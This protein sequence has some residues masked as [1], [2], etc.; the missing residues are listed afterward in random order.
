[1]IG[2]VISDS[3]NPFFSEILMGVEEILM[4]AGYGLFICNTNEILERE[5]NYLNKVLGLNVD[6]VIAA[7]TSQA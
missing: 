7:A 3:S 5:A 6:R 4:P 2:M 1:M